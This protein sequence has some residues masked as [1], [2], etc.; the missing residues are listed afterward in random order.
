MAVD[1]VNYLVGPRLIA[2]SLMVPCL[3]ML[4]DMV[5]VIGS[6]V[7]AVGFSGID[8]GAFISRMKWF[9]DPF[10]FTHGLYK[11]IVFGLILTLIGCYKGYNA[12]GGARG[13]GDATTQAV[14]IGSISIFVLD[15][16]L[17]AIL[18]SFSPV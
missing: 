16:V 13:V 15:Y 7:V 10:D 17:T 8:E 1:P 4:F 2:G 12:S 18:L 9:L 14:V 11:S 3:T 5:A 6:Y